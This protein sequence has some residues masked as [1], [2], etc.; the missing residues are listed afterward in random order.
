MSVHD[1]NCSAVP[2]ESGTSNDPRTCHV[3]AELHTAPLTDR[4]D[5][6]CVSWNRVWDVSP[7]S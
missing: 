2:H 1:Q 5:S 4:Q 7:T 3:L 6:E